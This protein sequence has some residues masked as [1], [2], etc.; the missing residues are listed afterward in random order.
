MKTYNSYI[1]LTDRTMWYNR[2]SFKYFVM[3]Y[4]FINGRLPKQNFMQIYNN[5][6]AHAFTKKPTCQL[7]SFCYEIP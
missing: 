3:T 1:F 5:L 7:Q 2:H 6:S 4:L